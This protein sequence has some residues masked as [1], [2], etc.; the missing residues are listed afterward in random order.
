MCPTVCAIVA[1]VTTSAAVDGHR[2]HSDCRATT[3]HQRFYDDI[4]VHDRS[5]QR[6]VLCACGSV[7]Q[8]SANERRI[9]LHG[10]G[11]SPSHTIETMTTHH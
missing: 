6:Y 8:G 3:V 1:T 4:D 10:D 5:A 11:R 2:R 7:T 9:R